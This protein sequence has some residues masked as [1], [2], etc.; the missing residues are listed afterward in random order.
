M[1]RT[2]CG[3]LVCEIL[4]RACGAKKR[5]GVTWKIKNRS[6]KQTKLGKR[7]CAQASVCDVEVKKKM[8]RWR[9][10]E[11]EVDRKEIDK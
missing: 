3:G 10:R 6:A 5:I 8:D 11:R 9:E 2:R 4:W 1:L 7:V